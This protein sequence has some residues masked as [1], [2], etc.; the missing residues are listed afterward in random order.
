MSNYSVNS[1]V[2]TEFQGFTMTKEKMFTKHFSTFICKHTNIKK[3]TK[4]TFSKLRNCKKIHSQ[5]MYQN[6]HAETNWHTDSTEK[7]LL[8]LQYRPTLNFWTPSTTQRCTVKATRKACLNNKWPSQFLTQKLLRRVI[9]MF[10]CGSDT[11]LLSNTE[12]SV[13]S[14]QLSGCVHN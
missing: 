11:S 6:L 10:N 8:L 9:V 13:T 14:L 1:S 5:N 12:P 2:S 3:I 4:H 7:K